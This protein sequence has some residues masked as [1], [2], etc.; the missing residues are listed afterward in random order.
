MKYSC[1]S[2]RKRKKNSPNSLFVEGETGSFVRNL[3]KCTEVK[4]KTHEAKRRG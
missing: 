1:E 3:G 4:R 2:E